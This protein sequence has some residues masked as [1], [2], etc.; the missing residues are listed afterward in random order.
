MTGQST[1]DGDTDVLPAEDEAYA[2]A[3]ERLTDP[4]FDTPVLRKTSFKPWHH[5]VKQIVRD[6]QWAHLTK[7]L[8]E[9]RQSLPEKLRYFTLPGPDLLDVRVLAKVC[10]PLNVKIEYFGFDAGSEPDMPD[11]GS[12][13]HLT[14][15]SALRQ[16]GT[17]S[18][19][20]LIRPDRLEDI[21]D[22]KSQAFRDLSERETFD[23]VN[24]DACDNLAYIPTGRSTNTFDAMHALLKHQCRSTN[25]WLLFLTTRVQPELLGSPHNQMSSAISANLKLSTDFGAALAECIEAD[26]KTLGTALAAAWVNHDSR[27]L[28]LYTVGIAKFL[29]QFFHNQASLPANV[30]LASCYSYRVYKDEPDMLALAFRITPDAPRYFDAGTGG[31]VIIP[32]LEPQ[33]AIHATKQAVKL[34]DLDMHLRDDQAIRTAAIQGSKELLQEANFDIAEW[35]KWVTTHEKR[36]V[37]IVLAQA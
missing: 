34:Q 18:D 2:Y 11:H 26:I 12:S 33:R 21:V 17:I 9:E 28:K 37:E 8:L 1:N 27:F 29:L 15:E 3:G 30:T 22:A 35:I 7:K 6:R 14:A 24:I 20:A 36:P 4:V 13:L 31:A 25:P 5:P 32:D 23:V 16:S 10:S 19:R